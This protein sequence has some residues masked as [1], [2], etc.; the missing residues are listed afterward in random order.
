MLNQCHISG[1]PIGYNSL[2]LA[3]LSDVAPIVEQVLQCPG[4]WRSKSLKIAGDKLVVGEIAAILA[5]ELQPI[6][7]FDQQVRMM[8]N[9][10]Y[11]TNIT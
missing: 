7:F 8:I 9:L 6:Q 10:K 1:I 11:I 4:K 5:V 2:D 3:S